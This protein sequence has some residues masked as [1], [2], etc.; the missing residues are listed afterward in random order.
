ME[1][2]CSLIAAI[3]LNLFPPI[4][5]ALFIM[6]YRS[7]LP[8]S[9]LVRLL[10]GQE[11]MFEFTHGNAYSRRKPV[12][13]TLAALTRGPA[14]EHGPGSG[15]QLSPFSSPPSLPPLPFI[16]VIVFGIAKVKAW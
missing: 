11:D 15:H 10:L 16:T 2:C 8:T 5:S 6:L 12:L 3:D 9:Q 1:G 4:F 13:T 14:H 7:S